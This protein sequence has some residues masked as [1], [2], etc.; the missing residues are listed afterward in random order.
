MSQQNKDRWKKFKKNKLASFGFGFILLTAVLSLFAVPLSPDSTPQANA[1]HLPLAAHPPGF[2]VK[3]LRVPMVEQ[4]IHSWKDFFLGSSSDYQE[5]PLLTYQLLNDS[6]EIT[7]FYDDPTLAETR[8][9]DLGIFPQ[10][11]SNEEHIIE[12]TFYLG[13][14][15]FGRDM[16]SRMLPGARIS[17]SVG[18]IAVFISM[19]VGIVL[20]SLSGYYGGG[21]D[22]GIQWL[23]NIIWSL[24]TLLLVIA[25][26]LALGKGLWQ[27]FVAIGLSMW[28]DVARLVRG[29]VLGLKEK[30]FVEAARV[31]GLSDLRILFRHI[32]PNL[33]GPLTVVAAANFA[34]AIL[35]EAGLSFLGLGVQ[36]PAPSWGQM[37]KEHYG[38]IVLDSAYL[39][40]IPGLAIMLLV[41][42]FNF[43]GNGLRDALDVKLK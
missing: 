23:M 39:A 15:R 18:L 25:F 37:I 17:I 20:G 33:V 35:L 1:I 16:L 26:A 30:E 27:I 42:S 22:R 12:R 29:Q 32:L 14:D 2:Q 41:M 38:Y 3:F 21:I 19:F 24:P 28:V 34:S 7:E 9:L 5:I 13:T 31:L 6:I 43:V 40:I 8:R 36:A 10:G 4:T 11:F